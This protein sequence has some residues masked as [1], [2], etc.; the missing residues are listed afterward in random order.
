MPKFVVTK[1]VLCIL[2]AKCSCAT[3]QDFP[4]MENGMMVL[5]QF[6]HESLNGA[7][8][9]LTK[10][11][12]LFFTPDHR[13]AHLVDTTDSGAVPKDEDF[14]IRG[15]VPDSKRKVTLLQSRTGNLSF[16]ESN[17][18]TTSAKPKVVLT[19]V[20]TGGID[21]ELVAR[22]HL[23]SGSAVVNRDFIPLSP[24]P[25]TVVFPFGQST[26]RTVEVLLVPFVPWGVEEDARVFTA[27]LTSGD[28]TARATV[29]IIKEAP[30]GSVGQV[31][32][33][34]RILTACNGTVVTNEEYSQRT[35]LNTNGSLINSTS[36]SCSNVTDQLNSSFIAANSNI[37]FEA[38]IS[39]EC[40]N[41][42][43]STF[44]DLCT[45]NGQCDQRELCNA[46]VQF[47]QICVCPRD[48][49]G[50]DCTDVRPYTCQ[51]TRK[52]PN[53][54]C[55]TTSSPGYDAS[56]VG[57]PPC[58]SVSIGGSL[59]FVHAVECKFDVGDPEEVSEGPRFDYA[60]FGW[61]WDENYGFNYSFGDNKS[62]FSV[63][64]NSSG[65]FR[66]KMFSFNRIFDDTHAF[67]TDLT[68]DILGG[69]ANVLGLVDEAALGDQFKIGGRIYA[70]AVI[71]DER[72]PGYRSQVAKY[73][74]EI[75]GWQ[76]PA[77]APRD[78]TVVLLTFMLSIV[79]SAFTLTAIFVIYRRRKKHQR[80][81][82]FYIQH[83]YFPRDRPIPPGRPSQTLPLLSE[84]DRKT[85]LGARDSVTFR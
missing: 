53:Y 49:V 66:W 75:D 52:S 12:Q 4:Q 57:P 35:G 60:S 18:S 59:N 46:T 62:D 21:G 65:Y 17:Y 51:L 36:P 14:I 11:L 22:I 56:L 44:S 54:T 39:Q 68:T 71:R 1:L 3:G 76:A 81:E 32:N 63:T 15:L 40:V 84:D 24:D 9:I 47:L 45:V 69:S 42:S 48:F 67:R 79:G 61:T 33:A 43:N 10:P 38:W 74:V 23:E 73:F 70:E 7:I 16:S 27:V 85:E 25:F 26:P 8:Q 55:Q 28:Y 50:I 2:V 6:I 5:I 19:I 41:V 80:D 83:G 58:V 72:L 77:A 82:Q 64:A 78:L 34:T 20:R 29:T 13:I 37:S 30:C 31:W